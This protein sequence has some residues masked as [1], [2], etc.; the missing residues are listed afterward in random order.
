MPPAPPGQTPCARGTR[1][2]AA[3]RQLCP[4]EE[5]ITD[6]QEAR[7]L[8]R[9]EPGMDVCDADGDKFGSIA[10]VYRH[11]MATVGS[12]SAGVATMPHEDIVEVKTGLFGL[13]KHLYVPFSAIQDV[14]SGCVF[15][16]LNKDQI[17]DQGWEEKPDYLDEMS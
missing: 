9:L 12:G 8:G 7:Y 3:L 13:G 5:P 2:A 16:H 17:H 15:V 6:M 1:S 4:L 10:R 14:T 11:E